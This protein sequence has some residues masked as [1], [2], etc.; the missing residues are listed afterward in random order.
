MRYPVLAA[1]AAVFVAPAW[2]QGF[3]QLDER[4]LYLQADYIED[5]ELES[6]GATEDGDGYG[7]KAVVSMSPHAFVSL[8]YHS[9]DNSDN[10]VDTGSFGLGLRTAVLPA[11][12]LYGSAHY[13]H[14]DLAIPGLAAG[15]T[16]GVGGRLGL[17]LFLGK[18]LEL[19]AEGRWADFGD[20]YLAGGADDTEVSS[21]FAVAG[22]VFRFTDALAFTAEYLTGEYELEG[23][24]NADV[25]RDDL[26][27]GLRWY[28][29]V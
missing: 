26:R 12:D 29:D 20:E 10:D 21:S 25:E 15:D 3:N 7:A 24:I 19:S 5:A 14:I 1:L 11:L 22:A 28:L 6:G 13:E 23:G 17:R 4:Y 18:H 8:D 2:G 9:I 16:Q 27:L